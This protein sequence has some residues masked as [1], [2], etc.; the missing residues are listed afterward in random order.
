MEHQK[1]FIIYIPGLF[2]SYLLKG[3]DI[4]WPIDNKDIFKIYFNN[5]IKSP[6]KK[7]FNRKEIYGSSSSTIQTVEENTSTI[8][9]YLNK[10]ADK[11]LTPGKITKNN[12]NIIELIKKNN[13][14]DYYVFNYDWRE[15]FNETIQKLSNA[16]EELD[17]KDKHITLLSHSA[18]GIIAYKYINDLEKYGKNKNFKKINKYITIGCPIEGCVKALSVILGIYHQSVLTPENLKEIIDNGFF[19]SIYELI[20]A[21]IHNLFFYKDTKALLSPNEIIQVLLK[22]GFTEETL[23]KSSEFRSELNNLTH[24]MYVDFLFIVGLYNKE[25]M[26]IGF[27]VDKNTLKV[28]CIYDYAGDGTVL[29]YEATPTLMHRFKTRYVL[30]KHT[31][32]TEYDDV[33]KIVEDEINT[34]YN[35]KH[36]V[37]ARPLPSDNSVIEFY[38]FIIKNNEKYLVKDIKAQKIFFSQK[39][40]LQDITKTLNNDKKKHTFSF[41]SNISY[42]LIKMKNT[43]VTYYENED[44]ENST[45]NNEIISK[46][47]FK[48]NKNNTNKEYFKQL[49]IEINKPE[50]NFLF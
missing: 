23:R 49:Y 20:P 39:T 13:E 22:N 50:I 16:I 27:D 32:L 5:F 3:N 30:G 9:E 18:G 34:S 7:L 40:Y 31:Y 11:N 6:L 21:N 25:P 19:K 42:G 38:L 12:D 1:N 17:V 44:I 35:Q 15:S 4:I 36:I 28:E 43:I 46:E 26:C 48:I 29:T 2:S 41:K 14:N 10:L 47:E 33:L 37:I 24:N 45:T 8:R